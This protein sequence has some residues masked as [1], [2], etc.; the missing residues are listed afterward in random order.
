MDEQQQHSGA[1]GQPSTP[2]GAQMQQGQ[3]PGQQQGG[4]SAQQGGSQQS[5]FSA[6]AGQQGGGSGQGMGGQGAQPGGGAESPQGPRGGGRYTDFLSGRGGSPLELLKRLD[7]DVDRLFHQFIGGGRELLRGRLRDRGSDATAGMPSSGAGSS[8]G[9]DDAMAEA[10]GGASSSSAMGSSPGAGWLPQVELCERGGRLHISMDLP[11]LHRDDLQVHFDHGQLVVQGERRTTSTSAQPGGYY[12][13]ERSYGH[14]KRALP[15][16]EGVNPDTAQA[17]FHNGVLD[18]S[19]DMPVRHNRSR[20]IP[21]QDGAP[22][23]G[24]SGGTAGSAGAGSEA[25]S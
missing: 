8:G 16:P 17:S 7:E 14:F 12:R 23:S 15:L 4:P 25:G 9:V 3:Q 24:M 19:F 18:V 11:G 5:Q 2:Q 10:P 1:P 13:S 6:N 22:G 21:I 20:Q